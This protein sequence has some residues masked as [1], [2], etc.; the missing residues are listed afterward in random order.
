[1][2]IAGIAGGRRSCDQVWALDGALRNSPTVRF[3]DVFR[4]IRPGVAALL[5][6]FVAT[7]VCAGAVAD[8]DYPFT[9]RWRMDTTSLA[10]NVKPTIFRLI[11]GSFYKDD[12]KPVEADGNLHPVSGSGYVDEQAIK[13]ESDHVVTEVDRVHGKL[14][15]TVEYRVSADGN[16]LTTNVGNYTNPEGQAVMS[17]TVQRRIG[18]PTKGAHLISGTWKRVSVSV[19]SKSDWII[20]LDGDHFSWR[21]EN[22][23]G[24]DA[25]VGGKSVKIDGDN[26][27][28]RASITRPRPDT[29]VETD[30]SAQGTFDD[31]L[32]M[33]L[34]PDRNTIRG[35]ARSVRQK[36]PTTFYL[37]RVA[38]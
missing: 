5:V 19:D 31:T 25:V 20:R 12:N 14:A 33:Q 7:P 21:T 36:S 23:T 30:F 24:F 27:G 15:Y 18:M 2:E 3:E 10:G 22:G 11:G 6:A 35:T 17:V 29:I 4:K 38:E 37:H 16:T 13:V 34:L 8:R 28:A 9:G 32:S 26:S 1:M